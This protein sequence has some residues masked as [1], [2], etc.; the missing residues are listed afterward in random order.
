[1]KSMFDNLPDKEPFILGSFFTVNKEKQEKAKKK[2]KEKQSNELFDAKF[3]S[4]K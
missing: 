3:T 2:N 1:M 4:Q